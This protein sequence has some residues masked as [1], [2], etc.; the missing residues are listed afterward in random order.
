[1]P[2]RQV[3]AA[4]VYQR[5]QKLFS[6]QTRFY[7]CGFQAAS[8]S[9]LMK[10]TISL[11]YTK[12]P[13]GTP[14]L[15]EAPEMPMHGC[16]G[17]GSWKL[18]CELRSGDTR[19]PKTTTTTGVQQSWDWRRPYGPDG[20]GRLSRLSWGSTEE[21]PCI[22]SKY[23]A[24]KLG[25]LVITAMLSQLSAHLLR[26]RFN[27]SLPLV[28]APHGCHVCLLVPLFLIRTFDYFLLFSINP[29]VINV[30]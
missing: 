4:S 30:G 13:C 29:K 15:T 28:L 5:S 10:G 3:A 21:F 14:A 18:L 12:E 6:L 19:E 23:L 2:C 25:T 26:T 22:W 27:D 11:P 17:A 8:N 9:R 7:S 24:C 20:R 16:S 1:M